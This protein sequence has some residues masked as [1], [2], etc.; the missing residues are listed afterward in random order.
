MRGV[1]YMN[2]YNLIGKETMAKFEEIMNAAKLNDLLK[3]REEEESKKNTL[4]WVFALLGAVVCIA[5]IAYA[6]YRFM[7]NNQDE[8]DDFDDDL[9]DDFFD[10]EEAE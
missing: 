10:E 2:K 8:Y 9:E 7:N 1:D 6:V 5:G 4:V 3:K